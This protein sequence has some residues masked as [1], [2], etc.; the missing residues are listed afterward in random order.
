[1]LA[2]IRKVSSADAG[3]AQA[4]CVLVVIVCF[5]RN[6]GGHI[7]RFLPAYGMCWH[8]VFCV[9]LRWANGT[10]QA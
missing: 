8:I 9:M 3:D 10:N 4:V 7:L 1:V 2:R 5:L 6:R